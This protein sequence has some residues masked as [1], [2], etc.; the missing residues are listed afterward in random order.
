M[1][2]DKITD[3]SVKKIFESLVESKTLINMHLQGT[4]YDQ[5]TVMT[6][7]RRKL[8]RLH[9][10]LGYPDGFAEAAA[11]TKNWSIEYEFTGTDGIPY[12]FSSIGGEI[13]RD[14][15]SIPFPHHLTRKQRRKFFRL[16]APDG[17]IVEFNYDQS[18][19]REKVVDVSVGGALIAM[20]CYQG[21]KRGDFP[22][23]EG[24]VIENLELSFPLELSEN[25]IRIKKATV[26][27][28]DHGRSKARTCCGLE[29]TEIDPSEVRALTEFVYTYQRKRLRRRIRPDM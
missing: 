13:Y 17:T 22:F 19:C 15:L 2:F 11:G 14:Q 12:M 21:E 9:F 18:E 27:R 1:E 23:K 5:L 28:F 25:R 3:S 29:F 16:E 4:K 10:L 6:G 24:D 8:G 20:V 7:F 26:V